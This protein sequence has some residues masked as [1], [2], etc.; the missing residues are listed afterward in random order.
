MVMKYD[1]I[2]IGSGSAA[3]SAAFYCSSLG[4]R[5]AV[6]ESGPMGGTCALRGCDPKKVLFGVTGAVESV[7]R[8]SGKGADANDARIDWPSL[9]KFKGTFTEPMPGRVEDSLKGSGIDTYHGRAKFAGRNSVVVGSTKLDGGKIL[10]ASGAIPAKLNIPGEE[11]AVDSEKFMELEELPDRIVFV[12]GGYI[13]VEFA[14]IA[15]RSGSTAT[16][17][18]RGP[19]LLKGFDRDLASRLLKSLEDSGIKVNLEHKVKGIEKNGKAYLVHSEASGKE[20]TIECDLVV[21]GSGRVPDIYGLGLETAGVESDKNGVLVN[22]YMQSVSN[23]SV[24]AAG[25]CASTIGM[26]LTPVAGLEGEAA[27]YNIANGN[28]R[29]VD[30][31]AIPTV[32]FSEPPLAMV[33]ETEEEAGKNGR[34][35]IVSSGDSS[36]WYNSR[37]KGLDNTG[38]KILIDKGNSEIIGAHILGS[39]SEEAINVFSLAMRY[40][41][42]ADELKNYPFAYPS[43]TTEIRYML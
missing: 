14:G 22:E 38:Y 36:S 20:M 29:K 16:I 15:S 1:L 28:S 18:H 8:L 37:R 35:F 24:Y 12:G 33:G 7:K 11:F 4:M 9:I 42:K 23:E 32:V 2:I 34:D 31:R 39:N 6:V 41:I 13:S 40:G 5:T 10:I 3:L 19:S 26:K 25:D 21:N 43:D 17:V 27:G 30:Y